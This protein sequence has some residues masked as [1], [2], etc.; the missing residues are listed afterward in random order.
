M[1]TTTKKSTRPYEE[2]LAQLEAII[3]EKQPTRID[4]IE[5][6]IVTTFREAMEH[7]QEA[8]AL[9]LEGTIVKDLEGAWKDGKPNWQ[10]KMKLDMNIDLKTVRYLYGNEG[11]KNE[12]GHLKN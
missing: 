2:R 11:T 6:R 3:K 1:N 12:N 10:V 8:L 4:L 9:D 7:F 5:S